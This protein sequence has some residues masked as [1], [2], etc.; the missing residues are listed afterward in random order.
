MTRALKK[1]TTKFSRAHGDKV[2][3][4][5]LDGPIGAA[6]MGRHGLT[7]DSV[8]PILKRAFDVDHLVAVVVVINSPGGSPAQS[9]YIAERIR[10]L[11]SE[12]GVPV[13]AF[14]EDIAASGGYWIACAADEI[15]AAHTS[16]VGS[17]GVVSSGF[18]LVDVIGRLGVE[19][20]LY[21]AGE[22]KARLDAFSPERPEDVEW[23]RGLQSQ[24]H[25]EFIAWVRQRRGR[26]LTASD[27][28]LFTGDVWIGSRAAEVGLVDGVGVLRSVIAERFPDATIELIAAPK[29][30]L[31]RIT[32][33]QMSVAG[34]S[35][36]LVSAT[37]SALDRASAVRL[38]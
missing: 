27:D 32:G 36:Q 10:Q 30:L 21:T 12:K 14:C 28:V 1:I 26:K 22:N 4:L 37:M 19:R 35:E 18:G 7:T 5:R 8:E 33:G 25:D 24:L 16:L 13:L 2:A 15:Y 9:E 29:P 11:S 23:L 34:F 38:G 6:G 3:V 31:E 20:R 17:I